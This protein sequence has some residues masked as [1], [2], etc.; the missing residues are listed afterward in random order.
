MIY[1]YVLEILT[2]PQL[3]ISRTNFY[4]SWIDDG[5]GKRWNGGRRTELRLVICL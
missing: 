4:P 5:P 1:D 2:P 3:K